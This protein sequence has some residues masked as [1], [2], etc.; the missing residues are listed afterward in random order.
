MLALA[1]W[2]S[3]LIYVAALSFLST[4]ISYSAHESGEPGFFVNERVPSL[5]LAV[6]SPYLSAW[7]P[8]GS[9]EGHL[10]GRWPQFWLGQVMGWT[11][12]IRVDDITYTFMGTPN[13]YGQ[14]VASQLFYKFSATQT[15]FGFA[16]GEVNF[17]VTFLSPVDTHDAIK[18]SLPFSY[19]EVA[20]AS[21]TEK[22]HSVEIYTDI[23]SD[24]LSSDYGCPVFW[25]TKREN[26]L[27]WHSIEAFAPQ[28]FAEH[29]DQAMHGRMILATDESPDTTYRTGSYHEVRKM[30]VENGRLD[31]SEDQQY[32][33]ISEDWPVLAFTKNMRV[34][35]KPAKALFVVGH[36]RDP[37]IS[38]RSTI[39]Q[40]PEFLSLLYLAHYGTWQNALQAFYV[41]YTRV[42]SQ[43]SEL[44]LLIYHEALRISRP[45]A[46]ICA[47][48]LRQAFATVE[49]TGTNNSSIQAWMKEISSNGNLNTVDVIYP[50]MPVFLYL[51]PHYLG[52]LIEPIL[53]Y[54]T[55]GASY[56]SCAHDLGM[57][58]PYATGP[59]DGANSHMPVEESGNILIIALAHAQ[60]TANNSLLT[61]YY[62]LFVKWTN[63]LM[64]KALIPEEQLTTDDFMG[65]ITNSSSLALKGGIAIYAM[66]G[67]ADLTGHDGERYR[68]TASK[69]ITAWRKLATSKESRKSQR[70][71][72]LNYYHE[73]SWMLAYNLY[74][75]KL[76]G[77]S[78]I[79]N[80]VY[81][82][83]DDYY[84]TRREKYGVPL[85]SRRTQ[86]KTDWLLWAAAA[87]SDHKI[88]DML[89]Q[90]VTD[91]LTSGQSDVPFGDWYDTKT[92]SAEG[93]QAR[94]VVGGH[95]AHLA[96]QAMNRR[97]GDVGSDVR[98]PE[99]AVF[100]SPD[101]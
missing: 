95:F 37:A 56:E 61:K 4:V 63:Y 98:L 55:E 51:A 89:I 36:I 43:S 31:N 1:L 76:L 85:D 50:A 32:R 99:Q 52:W 14:E 3:P 60:A 90:G 93:F 28:I 78:L 11:G 94:P 18:Q 47:L 70:H 23:A 91:F 86:T 41:D 8:V 38:S 66:G 83:Q 74:A 53:Q 7:L 33:R 67:I 101:A 58:Y 9:G 77:I 64:E 65:P 88:S 16:A 45:Y 84:P 46:M 80:S 72:L 48:S 68:K 49:L 97:R 82:E 96:L 22:V 81:E 24:F 20:V 15:V 2:A 17:N 73:S 59:S 30:F 57:H 21:M 69:Y 12:F 25:K 19:Y 54:Q 6:K 42:L 62:R 26:G 5:P 10:A 13:C 27:I 44:D 100:A 75:E 87:T 34:G 35:Q 29:A 39:Q 79:P 71:L 92:A 40:E